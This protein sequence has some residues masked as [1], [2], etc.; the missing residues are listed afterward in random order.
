MELYATTG[1][2]IA[3]GDSLCRL[4]DYC[5]LAIKGKVFATQELFLVRALES[6]SRVTAAFERD[7]SREIVD[8]LFLRSIDN[9]IDVSSGAVFCYVD[10]HNRFTADEVNG[11]SNLRRYTK[12][13]FKPGQCCELNIEYEPLPVRTG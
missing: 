11:E 4:F 3:V 7:G 6:R 12:R 13:H 8:G 5:K 1:K 10:L 2:N 9:R